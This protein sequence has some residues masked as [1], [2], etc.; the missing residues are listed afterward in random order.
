MMKSGVRG[1]GDLGETMDSH[2]AM[3]MVRGMDMDMI[4]DMGMGDMEV[5]LSR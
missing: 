3:G 4:R 2:I 1:R 5:R